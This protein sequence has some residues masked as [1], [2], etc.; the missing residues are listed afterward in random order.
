[1]IPT[2]QTVWANIIALSDVAPV[3]MQLEKRMTNSDTGQVL[4]LG[5]NATPNASTSA[6][7]WYI[8]KVL[9]DGNGYINR[10]QLPDNGAGFYYSWDLQAD[11]F[12]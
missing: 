10:V 5:W 8:V 6:L 11:Y 9:Y 12:S 7:T 4:Y 3:G 2:P 1:M